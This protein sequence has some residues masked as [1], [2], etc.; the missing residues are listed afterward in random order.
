[1]K[2]IIH[3]SA[4]YFTFCLLLLI[5][6]I[7]VQAAR[8][9]VSK[10]P[11]VVANSDTDAAASANA[12]AI[13]LAINSH[14]ESAGTSLGYDLYFP[15]G[16]WYINRPLF[17]TGRNST[18]S[19]D[20]VGVS[21]LRARSTT[22]GM[23]LVYQGWQNVIPGYEPTPDIRPALATGFYD[24]SVNKADEKYGLRTLSGPAPGSGKI[25]QNFA[26]F[27]GTPLQGG[28]P[29]ANPGQTTHLTGMDNW[30]LDLG[31]AYNNAGEM[32]D[33]GH[34]WCAGPFN[35]RYNNRVFEFYSEP[36]IAGHGKIRCNILQSDG[37]WVYLQTPN[38][39]PGYYAILPDARVR[40]SLQ[41]RKDA[42]KNYQ[43][44]LWAGDGT[45]VRLLSKATI[46]YPLT[47][48]ASDYSSI[49]LGDLFTLNSGVPNA[50]DLTFFG[51]H[52]SKS[53]RYLDTVD[54]GDTQTI[55]GA[56]TLNDNFRFFADDAT[57][58]DTLAYLPFNDN[59]AGNPTDPTSA[60]YLQGNL[61][62]LQHGR[63]AGDNTQKSYGLLRYHVQNDDA[64]GFSQ[65]IHDMSLWNSSK[66][67]DYNPWGIGLCIAEGLYCNF[68][69]L[70]IWGGYWG[71]GSIG[72]PQNVYTYLVENC[73][74]RGG[75]AAYDCSWN[76][77]GHIVCLKN[78]TIAKPGYT[79]IN[80]LSG[81]PILQDITIGCGD[82]WSGAYTEF[83]VRIFN[84][85][86]ATGHYPAIN[87]LICDNNQQPYP[88]KAAFAMRAADTG[89]V[90]KNCVI[91]SLPATASFLELLPSN[92]VTGNVDFSVSN[93][94]VKAAS[95]GALFASYVLNRDVT[96]FGRI[97]GCNA[98]VPV[99]RWVDNSQLPNENQ[100]NIQI[101]SADLPK[102]L[103]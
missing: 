72:V 46:N 14:A 4:G 23:V 69:N 68:Y 56:G 84:D 33:N 87:H 92:T 64:Y 53:A 40:I 44:S 70:D 3:N 89:M 59:Y 63:G 50:H 62:T 60:L 10:L 2:Q 29:G 20:G 21:L 57:L 75:D 15:A 98:K 8:I 39:G 95:G 76:E 67:I 100:G 16:N 7:P 90:L 27:L 43:L 9:D 11:G 18:M 55:N 26:S 61:V 36:D 19:G 6:V 101:F 73:S 1:M 47:L 81:T 80:Y 34:F 85:N 28:A 88:K 58:Q 82:G 93:N 99:R 42:N 71:I 77:V 97:Y 78:I 22:K 38:T 74:L 5:S 94:S 54:I 37:T 79:A 25:R 86:I 12:T 83:L 32:I 24:A 31:F 49:T 30:T 65:S 48:A 35:Q 51:C 52:L 41:V 13:Q 96:A 102:D 103:P 66:D 91:D 17:F 45:R